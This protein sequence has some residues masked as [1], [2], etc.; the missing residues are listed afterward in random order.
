MDPIKVT[1]SD[2]GAQIIVAY[3]QVLLICLPEN[4]TTGFRWQPPLGAIVQ[5]DKFVMAANPSAGA[6]GERV[7]TLSAGNR[8]ETL[9][10]KLTR[11]WEPETAAE[12]FTVHLSTGE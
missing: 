3:G 10:F 12:E 7:F 11:S 8:N 6:A 4:P 1:V 9:V 5:G 2:N